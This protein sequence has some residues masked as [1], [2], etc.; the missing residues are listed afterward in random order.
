M[1]VFRFFGASCDC[2]SSIL[3]IPLIFFLGIGVSCD[4][5]ST[6]NVLY[7]LSLYVPLIFLIID[8]CE[9]ELCCQR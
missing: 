1:S 3:H 7:G 2:L 4:K 9:H 6:H 5:M 8:H